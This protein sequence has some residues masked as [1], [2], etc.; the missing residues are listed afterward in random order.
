MRK[1][2][3]G[4]IMQIIGFI[5]F[6][7]GVI[8]TFFAKRIVIAKTKLDK[9]DEEE[10]QLLISGAVIAVKLSGLVVCAI[11]FLFLMIK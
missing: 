8:I 2:G 9:K 11:G 5:L 7:I 3:L 10:I 1:I 4:E 6:C